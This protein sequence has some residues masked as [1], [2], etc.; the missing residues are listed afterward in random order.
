MKKFK[1][2]D[3]PSELVEMIIKPDL[4]EGEDIVIEDEKSNICAAIIQPE[5]FR[6]FLKKIEEREDEIDFREREFEKHDPNAKTLD[7]L[8]DEIDWRGNIY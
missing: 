7:E 3:L 8:R 5:A 4:L 6:F 1:L 2:N